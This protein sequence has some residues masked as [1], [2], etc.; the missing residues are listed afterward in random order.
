[1]RLSDALVALVAARYRASATTNPAEAKVWIDR[2]VALILAQRGASAALARQYVTQFAR[3]EGF[4]LEFRP[5]AP[6][7]DRDQIRRSLYAT[8]LGGITERLEVGTTLQA[9]VVEATKEVAGASMRHTLNGARD[10]L[11]STL[12]R[13]DRA[14]GWVRVTREGCCAFC[15][16][17]ASRGAVFKGDSFDA[18]DPRFKDGIVP[19]DHK[20]H[21]N[22]RCFLEPV[23]SRTAALPGR[24][25]EFEQLWYDVTKV[26]S[27]QDKLK[28]YRRAHEALLRGE[29]REQAVARGLGRGLGDPGTI[30][31]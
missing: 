18:S 15:G 7:A 24:A 28:A 11:A 31:A 23:F 3:A 9:A 29:T 21:D 17:L 30:A 10:L 20:V 5:T 22:C 12:E 2:I 4:P 1:M 25:A 8:G 13:D 16:M 19:S 26:F 14:L 6:E 27:G